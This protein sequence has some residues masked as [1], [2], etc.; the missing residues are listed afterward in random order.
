MEYLIFELN[1][2]IQIN[3]SGKI[4]FPDN[5]FAAR[6][7]ISPNEGRCELFNARHGLNSHRASASKSRRCSCLLG[8]HYHHPK[9]LVSLNT[10]LTSYAILR[11]VETS[12]NHH[13]LSSSQSVETI[14]TLPTSLRLYTII[15]NMYMLILTC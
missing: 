8:S 5:G 1:S 3:E 6:P 12:P 9:P 13:H 11:V 10:L 4:Y 14:P 15:I 2:Q 7:P